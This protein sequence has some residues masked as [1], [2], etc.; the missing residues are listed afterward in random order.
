MQ[1]VVVVALAHRATMDLYIMN[2]VMGAI[3]HITLGAYSNNNNNNNN[4]NA[5][6]YP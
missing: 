1:P 4:N 5:V 3:Q 6:I 2:G